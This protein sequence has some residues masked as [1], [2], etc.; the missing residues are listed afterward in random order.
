MAR[1]TFRGLWQQVIDALILEAATLQ[2]PA[3]AIEAGVIE[4]D[5]DGNLVIPQMAPPFLYVYCVPG[6]GALSEADEVRVRK[7]SVGILATPEVRDTITATISDA[8]ELCERIEDVV[9][10]KLK[11]LSPVNPLTAI[12]KPGTN[13]I[14]GVL[15]FQARYRSTTEPE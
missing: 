6:V 13:V 8:V 2:V 1:P 12:D 11:Q 4:F 14:R 3:T 10:R 15:T 7:A 9:R 5:T